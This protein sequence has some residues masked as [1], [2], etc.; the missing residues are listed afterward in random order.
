MPSS[1]TTGIAF[2]V[3]ARSIESSS[4]SASHVRVSGVS[5]SCGLVEPVGELGRARNG[6]RDLEIG[7]IV[8]V[9]A[10]HERVLARSRGREVVHRLLAAHHPALRRD[11]A[12]L[13][14]AALEDSLVRALVRLEAD[15]EAGLVA[16]EGVRVLHHELADAEQ[17]ASGTRLVAVLRLEVVPGLRQLPVALEL[18]RVEGE[19]LLVRER[20]HV[21][22]GRCGPGA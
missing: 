14:A 7:R 6:E 11:A 3:A 22:R 12:R 9:L 8:A 4:A 20:E 18:H 15:V 13:E 19:R 21:A 1:L 16:V 17:A 2:V 10:R 5:T